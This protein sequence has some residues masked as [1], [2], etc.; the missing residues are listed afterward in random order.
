MKFTKPSL[1]G[2]ETAGA[3]IAGAVGG[4]VVSKGVFGLIH[5]AKAVTEAD[6]KKEANMAL[7]KRL[8]L[9]A[10][11]VVLVASVS[12]D[13]TTSQ[14]VKGAGIG[15]AST[16]IV[17][18]VTGYFKSSDAGAKLTAKAATSKASKFA[19]NALG[20]ACP[21]EQSGLGKPRKRSYRSGLRGL[22]QYIPV[23]QADTVVSINPF[24]QAMLEGSMLSA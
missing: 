23:P 21:C 16:Q 12:S 22:D 7:L 8:G 15:M 24:D 6:K 4:S 5:E 1:K 9:A 14:A 19:A 18:A 17:E 10:V 11:G 3:F 2:A 13:D 20:L